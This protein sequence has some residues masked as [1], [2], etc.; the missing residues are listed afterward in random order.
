MAR[1]RHECEQQKQRARI[2]TSTSVRRFSSWLRELVPPPAVSEKTKERESRN[3]SFSPRRGGL[4][5][6]LVDALVEA[7]A[8]VEWFVEAGGQIKL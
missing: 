8:V 5:D 4:P 6:G 3:H 1:M 7:N 2:R